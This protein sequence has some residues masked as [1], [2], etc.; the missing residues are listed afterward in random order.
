MIYDVYTLTLYS[1]A[2]FCKCKLFTYKAGVCVLFGDWLFTSPEGVSSES[3]HLLLLTASFKD[4]LGRKW[5]K[6]QFTF[7]VLKITEERQRCFSS[8]IKYRAGAFQASFTFYW[9]IKY[10]QVICNNLKIS[11]MAIKNLNKFI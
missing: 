1:P 2:S 7:Q 3:Q 8:D 10:K 6:F 9:I 4:A 5:F 11:F